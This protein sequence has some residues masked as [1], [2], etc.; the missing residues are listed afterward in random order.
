MHNNFRKEL[1]ATFKLLF[2]NYSNML[3]TKNQQL[4]SFTKIASQL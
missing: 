1:Y 4:V 3:S 2:K